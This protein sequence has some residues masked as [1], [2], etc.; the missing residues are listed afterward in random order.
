MPEIDEICLYGTW[1]ERAKD[2][3]KGEM[4]DAGRRAIAFMEGKTD[5]CDPDAA[6]IIRDL[7]RAQ[8]DYRERLQTQL[9]RAAALI[10]QKASEQ[11]ASMDLPGDTGDL[12]AMQRNAATYET[13]MYASQRLMDALNVALGES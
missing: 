8:D 4:S 12:I 11:V 2:P 7:L 10:Q 9:R 6:I 13:A 5:E 1:N 3:A